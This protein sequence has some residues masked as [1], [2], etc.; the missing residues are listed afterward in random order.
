MEENKT[1]I[2]LEKVKTLAIGLVGSGIFSQGLF[3]FKEQS[4]YN[5]PRILY[6][7]YKLFGNKGLALGMLVLGIALLYFGYFRWKKLQ[8]NSNFYKISCSVFVILF[9][10]LSFN[11]NK[12]KETPALNKLLENRR[13]F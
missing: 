12:S 8:E 2:F 3:Y 11:I 5:I 7:I 1:L 13:K 6:P 9:V 10:F 4:S